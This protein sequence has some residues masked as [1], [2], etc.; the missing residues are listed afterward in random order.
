MRKP[1]FSRRDRIAPA[2]PAFTASGLMIENVARPSVA[3]PS[4]FFFSSV[5]DRRADVGRRLDDVDAGGLHRLHLLGRGAL[6][7][8]DDRAGVAHAAARAARSGRR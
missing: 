6:A 2:L 1:A 7:A 3:L 8:G 4:Y 5:L